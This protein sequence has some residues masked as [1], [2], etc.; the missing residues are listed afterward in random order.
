MAAASATKT[1]ASSV[2]VT[3][4]TPTSTSGLLHF[5][6]PST[7]DDITKPPLYKLCG[8]I[9][10]ANPKSDPD[11]DPGLDPEPKSQLLCGLVDGVAAT[12]VVMSMVNFPPSLVLR[13]ELARVAV[14]EV[15][16]M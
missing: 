4:C 16:A 1:A 6:A 3:C 2:H 9:D 11:P 8:E 13:M 10:A 5:P 7:V 15:A 14:V 12:F